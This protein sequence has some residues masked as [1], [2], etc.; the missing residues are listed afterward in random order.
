[1]IY[2]AAAIVFAGILVSAGLDQVVRALEDIAEALRD[3]T[4]G[5]DEP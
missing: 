2:V 5:E 4:V 1:M 3:R